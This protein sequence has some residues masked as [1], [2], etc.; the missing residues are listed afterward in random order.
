[1]Q[2]PSPVSTRLIPP[3]SMDLRDG[4]MIELHGTAKLNGADLADVVY[5]NIGDPSSN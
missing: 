5:R 1:M 2:A 3:I 4:Y